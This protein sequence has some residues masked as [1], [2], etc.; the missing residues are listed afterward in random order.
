ME[1][2]NYYCKCY[3]GKPSEEN[4]QATEIRDDK[5][6]LLVSVNDRIKP[7]LTA[8]SRVGYLPMSLNR[9]K[10]ENRHRATLFSDR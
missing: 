1:L 8:A 5:L 2:E 9:L 4:K 3:I 10:T 6:K 7:N